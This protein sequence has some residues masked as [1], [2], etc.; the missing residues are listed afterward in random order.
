MT[1]CVRLSYHFYTSSHMVSFISMTM[2]GSIQ[3]ELYKS[4]LEPTTST[5]CDGLHVMACMLAMSPIEHLW[6]V[7]SCSVRHH[8]HPS[9]NQQKLFQA[10]QREWLCVRVLLFL[11]LYVKGVQWYK[12]AFQM[13]SH[14]KL[15]LMP[16]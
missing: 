8:L 10:L 6:D 1:C 16:I 15:F 13:C 7:I 11:L 3:P 14:L 5:C 4:S 12:S 2:P 9:D